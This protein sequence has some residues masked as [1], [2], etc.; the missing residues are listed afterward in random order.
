MPEQAWFKAKVKNTTTAVY[1]NSCVATWGQLVTFSPPWICCQSCSTASCV[2]MF[3]WREGLVCW[4]STFRRSEN[5]RSR[6]DENTSAPK[7]EGE[8]W[9]EKWSDRRTESLCFKG[10]CNRWQ[11]PWW[12]TNFF[13]IQSPCCSL[14]KHPACPVERVSKSVRRDRTFK[15]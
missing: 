11:V 7:C 3:G 6:L 9:W 13:Y 14:N 8:I 5:V 2:S 4:N 15:F 10:T 1:A 12:G